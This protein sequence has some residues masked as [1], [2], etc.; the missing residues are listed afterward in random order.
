VRARVR[1][2]VR[3]GACPWPCTG[4]SRLWQRPQEASDNFA[5]AEELYRAIV[6][7][8]PSNQLAAKRLITVAREGAASKHGRARDDANLHVLEQLNECVVPPPTPHHTRRTTPAAQPCKR[9]AGVLPCLTRQQLR[10]FRW[11]C[12]GLRCS[13][14]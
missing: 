4:D 10:G 13:F 3:A 6:K 5:A 2:R 7:E 1:V 11:P 9:P 12:G 8:T 14:V